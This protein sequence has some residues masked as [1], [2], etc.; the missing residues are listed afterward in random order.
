MTESM[1]NTLMYCKDWLGFTELTR[2]ELQAEAKLLECIKDVCIDRDL[3]QEDV[4][5]NDTEEEL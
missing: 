2:E 3:P 1:M 4:S 5:D